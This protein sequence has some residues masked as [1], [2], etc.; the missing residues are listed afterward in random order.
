MRR[1]DDPS[2]SCDGDKC[3]VA[4]T[5]PLYPFVPAEI[6][7]TLTKR[8]PMTLYIT[9]NGQ[10]LG[11][12]SL[13]QTQQFVAA[14]N[15]VLTDLAWYERLATWIPLAQVPGFDAQTPH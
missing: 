2:K 3:G 13:E 1:K 9:R 10:Q 8:F 7:H 6:G 4:G 5:S 12:Y 11:P 14:G 15:L